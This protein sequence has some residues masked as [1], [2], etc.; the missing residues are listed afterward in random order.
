[1]LIVQVADDAF[2][3]CIEVARDDKQLVPLVPGLWQIVRT[4]L[5]PE[6]VIQAQAG[7]IRVIFVDEGIEDRRNGLIF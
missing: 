3:A 2:G 5:L 1:M 7:L 6:G 4:K